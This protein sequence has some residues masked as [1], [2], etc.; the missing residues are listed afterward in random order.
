MRLLGRSL[1]RRSPALPIDVERVAAT[2][3]S[4]RAIRQRP[5]RIREWRLPP[6]APLVLRFEGLPM[7]ETAAD[8]AALLDVALA[9]L[10]WL[11]DPR[12]LNRHSVDD[13]VRHYRCRWIAKRDG[14]PRL[15][16]APKPR[17]KAAQR[18]SQRGQA[19][20]ID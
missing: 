18:A 1:V 6:V 17:L 2:V 13:A 11:A 7:L 5:V 16:E 20:A 14:A 15:L 4:A 19:G 10:D 8:V 9:D 12:G 3:A